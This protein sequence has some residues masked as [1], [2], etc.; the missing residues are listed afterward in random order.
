[1]VPL[2]VLAELLEA[3]AHGAAQL[4]EQP[5]L[6]GPDLLDGRGVDDALLPSEPADDQRSADADLL[7]EDIVLGFSDDAL[8]DM[9]DAGSVGDDLDAAAP[10]AIGH[11]DV[12]G[13]GSGDDEEGASFGG[14]INH[15]D[16]LADG[17]VLQGRLG[18]D[19]LVVCRQEY[20]K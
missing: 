7:V 14:D 4:A 11:D 3:P 19:S 13:A 1:M 20:Q 6:D 5:I 18:H 15:F 10:E 17:G 8:A 2:A 16:G 9:G 12:A